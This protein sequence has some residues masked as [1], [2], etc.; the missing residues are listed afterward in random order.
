MKISRIV[1]LVT[2]ALGLFTVGFAGISYAQTAGQDM[3]N[4]GH[5]TK[6]AAKDAGK[7]VAKGA[8]KTGHAIKNG[9]KKAANKTADATRKGAAKV[10]RKTD[11]QP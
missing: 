5:D 4:A 8:K 10:E 2:L 9:T 11:D 3:K 1:P 6:Q 7:G